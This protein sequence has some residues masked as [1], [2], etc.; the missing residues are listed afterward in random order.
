MT[1]SPQLSEEFV[2]RQCRSLFVGDF[3]RIRR[4]QAIRRFLLDRKYSIPDLFQFPLDHVSEVV[5]KL[6]YADVFKDKQKAELKFPDLVENGFSQKLSSTTASVQDQ[7]RR[8]EIKMT[9]G[10]GQIKIGRN[11]AAL[12][13]KIVQRVTP[14]SKPI[15]NLPIPSDLGVSTTGKSERT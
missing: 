12:K 6:L 7:S 2:F 14:Q 9:S 5:Q 15:V 13:D 3:V 10:Q 11:T 1:V 8:Q 4:F